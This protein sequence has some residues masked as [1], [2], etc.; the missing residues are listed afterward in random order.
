MLRFDL[1]RPG[2][3][4]VEVFD[5]T[6]RR[7]ALLADRDYPVGRYALSWSGRDDAGAAVGP[8]VYFVRLS[9]PGLHPQSARLA[10]VR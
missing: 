10:V 7:V 5:L 4:R 1:A 9:G 3:T 6:G 2:R 8:A